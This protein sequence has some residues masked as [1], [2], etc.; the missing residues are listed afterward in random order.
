MGLSDD[1]ETLEFSGIRMRV[2]D[3]YPLDRSDVSK[4]LLERTESK[5]QPGFRELLEKLKEEMRW[6]T[7]I[8][9][10]DDYDCFVD[11]PKKSIIKSIKSKGRYRL[12]ADEIERRKR[13]VTEAEKEKDDNPSMKWKKIDSEFAVR[14][15]I[16]PE[17]F[18]KWRHSNY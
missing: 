12:E 3:K 16:S 18:R 10:L 13:L 2:E 11:L 9:E 5:I 6:L 1:E 8:G 15:G 7:W 17:S 4:L 14:I